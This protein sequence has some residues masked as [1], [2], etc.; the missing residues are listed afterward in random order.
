MDLATSLLNCLCGCERNLQPNHHHNHHHTHNNYSP[1]ITEK[2][3]T[4][5]PPPTP[6]HPTKHATQILT[7]LLHAPSPGPDATLT[8][9]ITAEVSAA[10]WTSYL[11]ERVL[12]G[13]E[14]A[15]KGDHATWGEAIRE[16]YAHARELARAELAQLWEYV[17][18]H[19]VEV[20][21]EVLLTVMALGVLARLVPGLVR[22]LGFARLGPVEGSFAAW[23]QRLYGGYVPKGSFWS[24]L[25]RMGMTWD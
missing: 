12:H 18:E 5:E 24:F 20:A 15:L 4:I 3:P 2:Q 8:P 17:R 10:D 11:A 1:I 14:A 25:Q 21:A 19:P 9:L 16:A 23:W 7:I 22:V 6:S 13:I